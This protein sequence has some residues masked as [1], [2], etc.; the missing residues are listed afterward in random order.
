MT[1]AAN[2]FQFPIICHPERSQAVSIANRQTES[3]DPYSLATTGGEVGICI[4]ISF[5]DEKHAELP[6]VPSLKAAVCESPARQ[7]RLRQTYCERVP[8]GRHPGSKRQ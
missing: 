8:E 2:V 7:C 1:N 5:V 4:V 6:G 3:K